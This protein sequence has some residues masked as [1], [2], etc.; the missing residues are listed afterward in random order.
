M[1]SQKASEK[2]NAAIRTPQRRRGRER[3]AALLKAGEEIFAEKG[4]DAATMTEIA[5]RAGA[6]IGSLYQFFPTKEL[7]ADALQ[8]ADGEALYGMLEA[9][10]QTSEQM[11]PAELLDRLFQDL[12]A[13]LLSHPAFVL[14]VDRPAAD[15][16]QKSDRRNRMRGQ[17]ARLLSQTKPPLSQERADV[18]AVIILHLMRVAAAVSGEADLPVRDAVLQDLRAMLMRQV[19]EPR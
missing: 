1:S 15:K 4:F 11:T 16:A 9:L 14:L 7:L 6:S 10:G 13:F 18:L 2:D 17:I 19:N 5:A 8:T 3:V 12:S